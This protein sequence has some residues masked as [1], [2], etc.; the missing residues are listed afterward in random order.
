MGKHTSV[1]NRFVRLPTVMA[2]VGLSRSQIY[3]LMS[4]G[5]FP[6]SVHL[7][8]RAVAWREDQIIDWMNQR[9]LAA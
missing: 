9:L 5:L 8:S 7:T 6:Q 3:K 2:T 1:P 4:E